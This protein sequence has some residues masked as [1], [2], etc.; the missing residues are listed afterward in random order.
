MN[1]GKLGLFSSMHAANAQTFRHTKTVQLFDRYA[2]YN[3]SDPYQTP[4][5]LGIIPHL[6]YNIGAFFP[7]GG[8]ISITNSLVELAKD[9]GVQF[10]FNEKVVEILTQY[11]QATG[12]KTE[13]TSYPFDYVASNMD[14]RPTYQKLL[15]TQKA[16]KK[17]LNQ[18][19]I[20]LRHYFLL[21]NEY[22]LRGSG[23]A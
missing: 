11:N 18:P 16:P 1:L 20:K 8:M 10:H 5:T 13:Q 2:T 12:L 23:R 17:L 3:G 15:P 19:Q 14:I 9:L 7:E 21:G 4:A 6:E 22:S